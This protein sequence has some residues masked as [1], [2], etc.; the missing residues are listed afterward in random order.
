[1]ISEILE[2]L[3]L[4]FV[5]GLVVVAPVLSSDLTDATLEAA[6]AS[7][8][9]VL[10]STVPL[11]EKVSLTL[12]LRDVIEATPKGRVPDLDTPFEARGVTPGSELDTLRQELTAAIEDAVTRAFRP[13]FLLAALFGAL[14]AVPAVVLVTH[15]SWRD[16]A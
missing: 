16:V 10:D 6:R 14:A 7:A 1:M 5:I 2:M 12:E 11:G 15:P 3:A 13:S 4:G 9:V 8:A